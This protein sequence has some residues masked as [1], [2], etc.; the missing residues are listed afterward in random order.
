MLLE[1]Q[2]A[3]ARSGSLGR[4]GILTWMTSVPSQVVRQPLAVRGG[5]RR[6]LDQRLYL[7]F[8]PA[9]ALLLRLGW[10]VFVRKLASR[11]AGQLARRLEREREEPAAIEAAIG[12]AIAE[13]G[14]TGCND[15]A[16]VARL[17]RD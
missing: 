9:L 2:I 1:R 8:P 6:T 10:R 5:S 11:L 7:L 14:P 4:A 15:P 17:L 13:L 3:R 16:F 12:A